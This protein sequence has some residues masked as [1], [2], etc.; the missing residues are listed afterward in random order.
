MILVAVTFYS[1]DGFLGKKTE[2]DFI[3]VPVY[4]TD[5]VAYIPV[6]PTITGLTSPVDIEIGYDELIYVVDAGTQEIISY[7][8]SGR[9]LGRYFLKGVT[10]VSQD[11][12]LD[13]LA[14]AR[15]DTVVNNVQFSLPAIVRLELKGNSFGVQNATVQNVIIHPFF[16]PRLPVTTDNQASFNRIDM[17]ADNSYYVSR[18]G[19]GTNNFGGADDAV[20]LFS[21]GD[22]FRGRIGITVQGGALDQNYFSQPFGIAT[23]AE[24]PQS[25][26]SISQSKSFFFTSLSNTKAL[27]VQRVDR[28]EGDG[29]ANY[30]IANTERN[31]TSKADGFLERAFRFGTPTDVAIS[32]DGTGYVFVADTEKD[33]VYQFTVN[34]LEGVQPPVGSSF[35]KNIRV[36]FGGKG[37]GPRQFDRPVAVA[38]LRQTLYVVDQ[39]N[40]RVLTFKLSSDLV[41]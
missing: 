8:Q 31:D 21:A 4:S 29:G 32:G 24:P 2:L 20:L 37:S 10:S 39:G 5:Q 22:E 25:V 19:Q 38:Y 16:V 18:S 17:M 3:P 40:G 27:K 7:D 41:R 28:I 6:Q 36:S 34:G 12:T 11:R 9:E 14:L 26:T 13:L 35:R 33:S 23:Y 15:I 30:L 1:C